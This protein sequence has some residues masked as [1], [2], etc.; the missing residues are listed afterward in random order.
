[1]GEQGQ[2]LSQRNGMPI[3]P[4]RTVREGQGLQAQQHRWAQVLPQGGV[5]QPQPQGGGGGAAIPSS[6]PQRR[7]Q[8]VG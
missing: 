1:M 8:R 2:Q 5:H 6:P 3:P 7:E 4:L